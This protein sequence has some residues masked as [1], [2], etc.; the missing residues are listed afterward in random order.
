MLKTGINA[1]SFG[2]DCET[3]DL[4]R[5]IRASGFDTFFTGFADDDRKTEALAEL[6]AQV[7]LQYE[8]IHAPFGGLNCIWDEGEAGDEFVRRIHR[9]TDT[10]KK[11]GVGYFTLHCM[12]VPR[13]NVDVCDVQKWSDLGL[14]R[15]RSILEYASDCGVKACFENVEF[16][17]FELKR[18]L[19]VFRAEGHRSLGFTW[20][21]GHE[22]CYPGGLDVAEAFGDLL[23]GTHV[24]DNF[25]QADPHVITWDDDC[26]L[27]PFDGTVD[28]CRVGQALK[29][30]NYQG[31]V[32]LE[33]RRNEMIPWYRD[34]T[35]EEFLHM[36][37]ER[38]TQIAM[39][40]EE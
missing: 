1:N 7:G 36:A 25:G 20:D 35:L 2:F 38:V 30:W 15:F 33:V 28:F 26:H 6:G 34:R 23:V 31:T 21:V 5:M 8:S 17:Q 24:H 14:S 9:V 27:L 3:A 37:H 4:I 16:P 19:D 22:H 39:W 32:T 40:C 13:F 29:R 11:F 10:C 12:N 18:L